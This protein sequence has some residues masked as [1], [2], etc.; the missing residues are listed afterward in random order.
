MPICNLLYFID[1]SNRRVYTDVPERQE[2]KFVSRESRRLRVC[3]T[4][5][6]LTASSQSCAEV[7]PACVL[8][9]RKGRDRDREVEVG[10][11]SSRSG[12]RGR[13]RDREVEVVVERS[14]SGSRGRGRGRDRG[15]QRDQSP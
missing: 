4:S 12:L 6:N 5:Q 10:V 7:G 9:G 2:I 8:Y 3:V 13:G 14:R 15:R 11:E 1:V